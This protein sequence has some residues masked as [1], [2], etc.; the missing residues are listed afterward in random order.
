MPSGKRNSITSNSTGL[1]ISLFDVALSQDITF[2]HTA[3]CTMDTSW[4]YLC[5]PL[6]PI[7][8]CWQPKV[9]ICGSM[10]HGFPMFVNVNGKCPYFPVVTGLITEPLHCSSFVTLCNGLKA[11]HNGHFTFKSVID[12]WGS[13]SNENINS[14]VILSFV[15]VH[16]S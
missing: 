5:P 10:V 3:V 14:G 1:V 12:S 6:C 16:Q 7:S 13:C 2:W 4:T 15:W 9:L 11:K 8:F